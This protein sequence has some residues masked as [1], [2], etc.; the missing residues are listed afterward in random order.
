MHKCPLFT[1]ASSASG[2]PSALPVVSRL[3]GRPTAYMRL[4]QHLVG[5]EMCNRDGPGADPTA[6][7]ASPRAR[8]YAAMCNE[9]GGQCDVTMFCDDACDVV[10]SDWKD[11]NCPAASAGEGRRLNRWRRPRKP[12]CPPCVQGKRAGGR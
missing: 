8:R 2:R 4:R 1:P 10:C 9:N 12:Y 5:Q 11:A 3:F 6:T 7:A